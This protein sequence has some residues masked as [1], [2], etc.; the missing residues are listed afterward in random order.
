VAGYISRLH[1][2][3]PIGHGD[4]GLVNQGADTYSR[5]C[6]GCHG[7]VAEG[8][9]TKAI[10]RLAG[11]HYEYLRRQIYDAVDG[12]RPNFSPSHFRLLARLDRDGIAGMAAYLSRLDGGDPQTAHGTD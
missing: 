1:R 6:R 7:V 5:L 12:A 10:P 9:A 11:Q 4:G 8:D 2:D 3:F